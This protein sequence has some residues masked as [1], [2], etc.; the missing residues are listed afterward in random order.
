MFK[1]E[2]VSWQGSAW[3]AIDAHHGA[4][5]LLLTQGSALQQAVLQQALAGA[6]P[7][8]H[9]LPW[10]LAA[11]FATWPQPRGSRF[12]RPGDPGVLYAGEQRETAAAEAGYWRLRMWLDSEGLSRRAKV[13]AMLMFELRASS[14]RAIDL[15]QPPFDA[16]RERWTAPD[17]YGPAQQL[18]AQARDAGMDLL[19]YESARRP[20]YCCIAVLKPEPLAAVPQPAIETAQS[21]SV[22]IQP[23]NLVV[24]QRPLQRESWPFSY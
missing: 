20:A 24:W 10:W 3:R 17:D 4:A 21:W 19:R 6:Q 1:L 5:T 11:P 16:Q 23:P 22:L 8:P 14:T 9:G 15:T 2:P 7:P 18:A 13:L 12:R